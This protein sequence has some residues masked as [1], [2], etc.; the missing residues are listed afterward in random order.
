[1]VSSCGLRV[2]VVPFSLAHVWGGCPIHGRFANLGVL[3]AERRS[4]GRRDVV[5]RRC[6]CCGG[7]GF[8]GNVTTG[9]GPGVRPWLCLVAS[10]SRSDFLRSHRPHGSPYFLLPGPS[11][12]SSLCQPLW[13]LLCWCLL[14]CL[15]PSSLGFS[16]VVLCFF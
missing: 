16:V 6:G 3:F 8:I 5:H 1:L 12:C 14:H 7:L 10:S 15:A 4:C 11:S 2:V 13:C 9:F